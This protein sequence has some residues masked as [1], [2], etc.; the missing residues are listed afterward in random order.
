MYP[1]FLVLYTIKCLIFPLKTR[2]SMWKAIVSV[3]SSPITSPSFIHTY[4]ADVFTS[5]VKVFQD[6]AWTTCFIASGD[7]LV[8]E[9]KPDSA[10][11][12]VHY[13]IPTLWHEKLWYK[14]V[15][16][17]LI[18]LFPLWI[19]F[20]QCLRRYLDTGKRA[21]HLPNALKVCNVHK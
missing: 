13:S 11:D 10:D 20:N 1:L 4:I 12:D 15:L 5:M 7:F 3:V 14:N 21:P 16:I 6:I 9:H 17:P 19:R 8:G 18:C 2:K